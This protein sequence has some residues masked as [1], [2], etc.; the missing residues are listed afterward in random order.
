MKLKPEELQISMFN[1]AQG[2]FAMP[3]WNGVRIE[4]IPTG[5]M[6]E[7]SAERSQHKN[8]ALAMELL[9]KRLEEYY[10]QM[11][12]ELPVR[13]AEDPATCIDLTP[14]WEGV[15]PMLI[16][17]LENGSGNGKAIATAELKRMA[18]AA[19]L[20]NAHTKQKE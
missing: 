11:P 16:A 2:G 12:Q 10:W 14:I 8:K 4:H 13:E 7:W 1:T 19:D 20:W 3:N 5:V 18:K 17:V 9:E 15:L 6:A